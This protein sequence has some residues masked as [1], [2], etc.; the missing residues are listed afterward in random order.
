MCGNGS[1]IFL[2]INSVLGNKSRN[3][4][5]V[6]VFHLGL[7]S[8]QNSESSELMQMKVM[9]ILLKWLTPVYT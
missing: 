8:F 3:P 9:M 2:L 4:Q 6:V 7:F 5:C 1:T